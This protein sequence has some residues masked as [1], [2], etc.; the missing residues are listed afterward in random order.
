MK[1]LFMNLPLRLKI[2]INN[3][4][5]VI[6]VVIFLIIFFYHLY[7]EN[8]INGVGKYQAQN[9]D[10]ISNDIGLI[11]DNVMSIS[12]NIILDQRFQY[13]LGLPK[14]QVPSFAN[15]SS[16]VNASIN[17]G[18]SALASNDY[19]ND[20]AVYTENGYSFY[21]SKSTSNPGN[22][23]SSLKN[24]PC[25]QKTVGLK[26]QPYWTSL[27]PNDEMTLI[28]SKS[29][30]LTLLKGIVDENKL[31]IRGLLVIGINW[32]TLWSH[33]PKSDNYIYLI[34]D[35]NGSIVS[36]ADNYTK[37]QPLKGNIRSYIP[38]L[39]AQPNQSVIDINGNKFLFT[40]SNIASGSYNVISLL[41][42]DVALMDVKSIVPVLLALLLSS[43]IFSLIVS[44]YM[45][46]F[47]TNPIRKLV[48]AIN[49]AK[50][51]DLRKKVNFCYNDE[52]GT[53]GKEYNNLLDKLNT[54]F[55]KVLQLEIKNRESEIKALQEK[56]NPHFLYNTLDSIY[57]KA[58]NSNNPETA[59]MIYSLS[60]IF[61][62]TLNHGCEF[63]SVRDEKELMSNYLYLQ[64]IRYKDRLSYS[65]T[66][67]ERMLEIKIP[68]LIL[69]PFVE[70]SITH[71]IGKNNLHINLEIEGY[72]DQDSIHFTIRDNGS[73][74]DPEILNK[75][76]GENE[77]SADPMQERFAISNVKERLRLYYGEK[78][79]FRISSQ[80][81]KGTIVEINIQEKVLQSNLGEGL[82]CTR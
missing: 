33:V 14:H 64:K 61:R 38:D 12:T 35:G 2:T 50:D 57:L 15:N 34:T 45:S 58:I 30:K 27:S 79:T 5:I 4:I 60:H 62:I 13:M 76:T 56:I 3:I 28:N 42:L 22:Q 77:K 26:G 67:E 63:I 59:E 69:Q 48:A 75:I 44:I 37:I 46:S 21:Y 11:E 6:F 16:N 41:P 36:S 17:V 53:L 40:R 54:L 72:Y 10:F 43:L 81:G 70:N 68:K 65:I 7:I 20:I 24:L 51:G 29:S 39:F 19:V 23:Y 1:K 25:V 31:E 52:I 80:K 82:E 73:G 55:N 32:D 9:T 8:V 66:I 49:Q 18:L 74:I 47:V 78:Q 71:G